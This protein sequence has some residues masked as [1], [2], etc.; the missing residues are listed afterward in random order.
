MKKANH[1][2]DKIVDDIIIFLPLFRGIFTKMS[3]KADV[4]KYRSYCHILW[5][6]KHKG[7]IPMSEIGSLYGISKPNM[8]VLIDKLITD[9]E[10]L[11]IPDKK[12]RRI[13][14]IGITKKGEQTLKAAADIMGIEIKK[15]LS[16]LSD[17]EIN[18]LSNSLEDIRHI[19]TKINLEKK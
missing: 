4:H 19:I 11:R 5:A 18:K 3:K 14:K 8:T 17:K 16:K 6:L 12:D 10:V 1:N 7:P 2:Y 15:R 13:I 9:K